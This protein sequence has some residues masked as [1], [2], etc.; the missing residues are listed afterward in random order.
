MN[1][2]LAVQQ[3]FNI[4]SRRSVTIDLRHFKNSTNMRS[5]LGTPPISKHRDSIVGLLENLTAFWRHFLALTLVAAT[6]FAYKNVLF[7]FFNAEDFV[8]MHWLRTA[9]N[10]PQLL[11]QQFS[12]PWLGMLD[13]KYYRPLMMAVMSVEYS[14]WGANGFYFR[15]VN[16]LCELSTGLLLGLLAIEFSSCESKNSRQPE[17]GLIW[18]FLAAALFALYPLHSESVNWI[19][20]QTDLLALLFSLLSFWCYIRWRR[21]SAHDFFKASIATAA[22]AFLSKE[23]AVI[24]PIII[25]GYEFLLDDLRSVDPSFLAK[26]KRA[27]VATLPYW[28]TLIVYTC[29]RRAALGTFVGGWDNSISFYVN[30]QSLA[31]EWFHALR[32]IFVPISSSMLPTNS[33]IAIA[34]R[35]ALIPIVI[36]SLWAFAR[37]RTNLRLALFLLGWFLLSLAPLYRFLMID[38]NLL[39]SRL[40][41][42]ATAPLCLFLTYGLSQFSY[43]PKWSVIS[44]VT[45]LVFIVLAALILYSN[46]QAWAQSGQI[47]NRIVDCLRT[48]YKSTPDDPET[49]IIGLPLV[50]DGVYICMNALQAM[51]KKPFLD[52]DISNCKLLD[53]GDQLFPLGSLKDSIT[54]GLAPIRFFYWDAINRT[55]KPV[56]LPAQGS[57][58][59]KSWQGEQLQLIVQPKRDHSS[60]SDWRSD[61]SLNIISMHRPALEINL[62]G[63]PCWNTDFI[64]MKVKLSH[65]D[66]KFFSP[67]CDLFYTNDL[68][69]K[70]FF[71][72]STHASLLCRNEP[73]ELIFP[74]RGLVDWSMGGKCKQLRLVLPAHTDVEISEIF[75]PQTETILPLLTTKVENGQVP[76]A[77]LGL[78]HLNRVEKSQ[79]IRYDASKVNGCHHL[80]LEVIKP[81]TFFGA[82]NP[83]NDDSAPVSEQSLTTIPLS[84]LIGNLPIRRSDFPI[85]GIYKARLHALDRQGKQVGVSSDH[86]L[87]SVE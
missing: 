18:S 76:Q 54:K 85:A 22:L 13:V 32:M 6:L 26:I 61:G 62:S 31:H 10:N 64:A 17:Q 86:I 33:P 27:V 14:L 46:N 19:I 70:F 15:L 49:R 63:L 47:S 34:W 35:I 36:S 24:L 71:R 7:N 82:L 56:K 66:K 30:P 42:F 59:P 4:T 40:A 1:C 45:G 83:Q 5:E 65:T 11:V 50:K 80:S 51:T 2:N 78:M 44:M 68:I 74:L 52:R 73:Q 8:L 28:L 84:G 21:T 77:N 43:K 81:N 58:F 16:L 20:C 72:E 39:N 12:G 25:F 29:I 75:I 48:T 9:S 55:L 3:S 38:P 37:P 23:T 87:L 69:D 60:F 67:G 57:S 53:N 41:Y 79:L